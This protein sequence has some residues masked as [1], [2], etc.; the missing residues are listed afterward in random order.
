MLAGSQASKVPASSG[1]ATMSASP[2]VSTVIR[3][4]AFGARALTRTPYRDSSVAAMVVNAAMPA[5]AAP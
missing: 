2:G 5:L 4:R 1:A 3:V